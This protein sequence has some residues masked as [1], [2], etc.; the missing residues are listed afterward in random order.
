M[1]FMIK[2]ISNF[3]PAKVRNQRLDKS[4]KEVIVM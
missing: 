1:N 3:N 2:N 4:P